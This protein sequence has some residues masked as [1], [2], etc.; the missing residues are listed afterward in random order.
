MRAK[1]M[2]FAVQPPQQMASTLAALLGQSS[3]QL[4]PLV[5]SF[6][7]YFDTEAGMQVGRL[8]IVQVCLFPAPQST[9]CR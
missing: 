8:Q 6:F 3:A 4:D 7:A 1:C 5:S 9:A 2:R